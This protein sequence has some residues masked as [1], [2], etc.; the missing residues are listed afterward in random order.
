MWN[1]LRGLLGR[2]PAAQK[3]AERFVVGDSTKDVEMIVADRRRL[4]AELIRHQT[5][6]LANER[7]PKGLPE[8]CEQF[9]LL[10]LDSIA[11]Q[12]AAVE[13]TQAP[14]NH[15]Y[16]DVDSRLY[17]IVSFL[18][19]DRH[20]AIDQLR[21]AS[22]EERLG[23]VHLFT[24]L[25]MHEWPSDALVYFFHVIVLTRDGTVD[26]H[27]VIGDH[28]EKKFIAWPI[29]LLNDFEKQRIGFR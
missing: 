4:L 21:L 25:F 5:P 7:V 29:N 20:E 26:L 10:N 6:K 14:A 1:H 22:S 9:F 28:A 12:C 15:G 24:R 16:R 23:Y 8:A 17:M 11:T 13:R 2:K 19:W 3:R 18:P 27:T